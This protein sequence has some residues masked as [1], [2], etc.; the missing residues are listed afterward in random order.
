[1]GFRPPSNRADAVLT[2]DRPLVRHGGNHAIDVADAGRDGRNLL[3]EMFEAGILFLNQRE[4]V[5]VDRRNGRATF[6]ALD[7]KQ[8]MRDASN[9]SFLQL[10]RLVLTVW[11]ARCR[12]DRAPAL[13]GIS[14]IARDSGEALSIRS[15]IRSVVAFFSQIQ[16]SEWQAS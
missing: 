15:A 11:A 5:A 12:H 8:L 1:L 9:V 4:G 10:K 2:L 3:L 16:C 7:E 14:K 13:V 6:G